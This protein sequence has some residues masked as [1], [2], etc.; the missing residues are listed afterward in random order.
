M[1]GAKSQKLEDQGEPVHGIVAEIS[2]YAHT[3]KLQSLP[4]TT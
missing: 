1:A 2:T 3:P 4:C